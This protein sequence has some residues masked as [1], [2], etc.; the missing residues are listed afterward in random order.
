MKGLSRLEKLRRTYGADYLL[1]E[2]T[3]LKI[4][5]CIIC[6][7]KPKSIPT[8]R[9]TIRYTKEITIEYHCYKHL[10]ELQQYILEVG[11]KIREIEEKKPGLD[12]S[13]KRLF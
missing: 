7:K 4:A 6:G 1:V 3:F 13:Q 8:Y 10:N 12:N 5:E 11:G 9:S 2:K